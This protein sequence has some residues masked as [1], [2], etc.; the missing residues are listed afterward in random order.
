MKKWLMVVLSVL[1]VFTMAACSGSST[2]GESSSDSKDSKD[3]KVTLRIAW[4][5]SEPRHDY[6]LKM[7]E[8]YE[9]QNPNV[10]IQP[11]YASWD[12]YWKKLA[13]Q[14]S[15]NQ[16]PDIIQMDLSYITQYSNNNQLADLKPFFGKEIDTTDLSQDFLDGGK[17][18]ENYYGLNGGV[19]ALAF[20]YDPEQLKKIGVDKISEDWTWDDYQDMAKK[21]ADAGLFF[22]NG[23]GT[24]PDVSFN[25]YLRT[26]GKRLYSED[27]TTLGYEDD[28]LFTDFFSM[29]ADLVKAK[30]VQSP[31][32]SAQV[33]GLEDDPVVKQQSIGLIQWSNQFIGIQEAAN[34]PLEM[35]GLPGPNADQ[36]LFLKPGLFWSVANSSKHKEEAAK[37]INFLTND[38]EANKLML[39]DRGVPGS[40]KVQ[41]ALLPLLSPAQKQVFNYVA[42]AGE[43]SSP[44]NGPDPTKAAEVI[45]LLKNTADQIAY[46]V[47]KPEEAAKQFRQQAESILAQG[48]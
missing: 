15:A 28:K 3:D 7:I 20:Q 25:Y 4:W 46:G 43:N 9:E 1:M 32:A 21:A 23:P 2:T 22:E 38:I 6:T 14:A 42:W 24:A 5:G 41:E 26:N 40:P 29:Y 27:G 8:L 10:K 48:Q 37:F 33:K 36:G 17:I 30:A 34:R 18:G 13:P 39:G 35:V 16:L 11:E 19:N 45:N 31:D 44:Y 12:D 47:L